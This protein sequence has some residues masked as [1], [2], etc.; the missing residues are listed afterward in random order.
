MQTGTIRIKSAIHDGR[1]YRPRHT[2]RALL[3]RGYEVIPVFA[4][5]IEHDDGHI[6]IDT[7]LSA[8]LVRDW[9][10]F[11]SVVA[12]VA[13]T[14]EDEV[15]PGLRRIGISPE[16]VRLVV[17]THM[18][19]DHG[20]GIGHFPSSEIVIHRVEMD[21][22]MKPYANALYRRKDWPSWFAPKVYDLEPEPF[23]PFERSLRIANGVTVVPI[24]GHSI[25]QVAI[26]VELPDV[27]I[28]FTGDHSVRQQTF[29][30]DRDGDPKGTF[31][32]H[33]KQA[34]DTQRRLWEFATSRPTVFVPAHDPDSPARLTELRTLPI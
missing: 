33:Y 13:L 28:L 19:P 11:A 32:P 7:G 34:V 29:L 20:G 16:D 17:P 9:P 26:A 8:S 21:F 22:A 1:A 27:T 31:Y 5:L 3:S 4:Y 30:R 6:V 25:G 23:G 24:P 14:D 18:H 15:G 12:T 2:L 10:R